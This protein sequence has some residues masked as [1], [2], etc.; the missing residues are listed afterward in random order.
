MEQ[1]PGFGG[2]NPLADRFSSP[3]QGVPTEEMLN[4]MLVFY[5]A[6]Q[7]EAFRQSASR[8]V[9]AAVEAGKLIPRI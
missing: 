1:K 9:D 7:G 4:Q 8:A 2:E 5:K 6:Q 3:A